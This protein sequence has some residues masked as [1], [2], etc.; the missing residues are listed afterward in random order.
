VNSTSNRARS[1]SLTA[2]SAARGACA[3]P[4]PHS[5]AI[6]SSAVPAEHSD[7]CTP[8]MA[9]WPGSGRYGETSLT[10]SSLLTSPLSFRNGCAPGWPRASSGGPARGPQQAA[11]DDQAGRVDAEV[12]GLVPPRDVE[13]P[14]GVQ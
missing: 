4:R 10:Y 3:K 5:P 8:A 6:S 9:G 13:D 14:A 12:A 2:M 11:L 1:S 7:W